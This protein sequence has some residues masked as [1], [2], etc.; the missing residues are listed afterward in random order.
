MTGRSWRDHLPALGR[1]Q[2]AE[3]PAGERAP[4]NRGRGRLI[5]LL[6]LFDALLI[7]AVLLSFQSADL[8][9]EER[10]LVETRTEYELLYLDWTVTQ[11]ETITQL[12]PYGSVP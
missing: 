9:E 7:A 1:A 4:A 12:L 10:V 6:C 11:T 2:R 5:A 8:V 3:P